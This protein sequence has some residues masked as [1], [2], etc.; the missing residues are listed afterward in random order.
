MSA[1]ERTVDHWLEDIVQWGA[2]IE[3]YL[4]GLSQDE[5]EADEKT[6]DAVI[7]C[8]ECIGEASKHIIS[9]KVE[10]GLEMDVA[11]FQD[12]LWAQNRLAHGYFDVE[13]SRIWITA[14]SSV[15]ALVTKVVSII[16]ARQAQ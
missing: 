13:L 8:I 3:S 16:S 14:T 1:K 2:R 11:D 15:P 7:R 12:A 6:Q 10:T 5:F 9:Y 4:V